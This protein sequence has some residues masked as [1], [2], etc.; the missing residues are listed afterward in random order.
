MSFNLRHRRAGHLFQNRFKNVLVEEE[1]YLLELLRYIHLNPVS[2]RLPVTIDSLAQYAWTGHASL[3][4]VHNCAAQDTDFVL[5]QFGAT[6]GEAR[7]AYA[8][9]VREGALQQQTPDLEGGGL[10][11]SAGG[12]EL[13]PRLSSG[14]ERWA[15]DERILGSSEFVSS[16]LHRVNESARLIAPHRCERVLEALCASVGA[17]VSVSPQEIASPSLRRPVLDARSMVCHVA[18]RQHGLS[19]AAV[20][21]YVHLSHQSIGRALERAEA[22]FAR[23]GCSPGSLAV[24]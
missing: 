11:R 17:L 2:S 13:I 5:R 24:A 20:A 22:A 21:R 19:P 23:Y 8:T 18:V 10:R 7:R 14:R 15:S 3:L 4:G 1:R 16:I 12:W 9:F 6:V